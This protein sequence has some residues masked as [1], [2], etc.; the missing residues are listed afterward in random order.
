[1]IDS[2][3][4]VVLFVV[5]DH[6]PL[7]G[8]LLVAGALLG[9]LAFDLRPSRAVSARKENEPMRFLAPYRDENGMP[10]YYEAG[11]DPSSRYAQRVLA[12]TRRANSNQRT[13]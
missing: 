13:R 12:R 2:V 10:I 9:L 4:T 3:C 8:F 5:T 1:M 7:F 6:L 11:E